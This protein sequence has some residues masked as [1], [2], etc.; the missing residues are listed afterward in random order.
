MANP[1]H[2][3]AELVASLHNADGRVAVAGFYDDVLDSAAAERAALAALP[4]DDAVYQAQIGIARSL[5]RGGLH[6]AG[7]PVDPAH[8]GD[9][10]HV[11]RLSGRGQQDR[12]PRPRRTAKITCRLVADQQP[13]DIVAKIIRHLH[14]HTPPGVTLAVHARA[15]TTPCPT[16]IPADHAGLRTAVEVLTDGL[17]RR[18]RCGCAW[19]ARCPSASCSCACWASYTVFF[20]FSTADEDFHA[21]NEFFRMQRLTKA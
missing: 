3:I 10:R 2:A 8:A 5:R 20:S 14:A 15:G 17:R 6:H 21:P 7:A 16:S 19:A 11:G 9:Q 4:F 1:L 18:R 12:H 13:D